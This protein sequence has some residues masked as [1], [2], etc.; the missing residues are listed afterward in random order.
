MEAAAQQSATALCLRMDEG[1]P[2]APMAEQ[3]AL[4]QGALDRCTQERAAAIDSA[5]SA[6]FEALTAAAAAAQKLQELGDPAVADDRAR[7]DRALDHLRGGADTDST[8]RLAKIR[9]TA[10]E[11]T[12]EVEAVRLGR[13][14]TLVAELRSARDDALASFVLSPGEKL[15][16]LVRAADGAI[17]EVDAETAAPD[18]MARLVRQIRAEI[19]VALDGDCRCPA[20]RDYSRAYLHHLVRAKEILGAMLLSQHNLTYY[21]DLMAAMRDAITADRLADFAE[22]FQAQQDGGDIEPL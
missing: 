19:T 2:I 20:C 8:V 22:A 17:A 9:R 18:Q 5:R 13:V 21:Q 12:A 4:L 11:L 3:L 14:W 16:Q 6:T 15:E 1:D 10:V 7:L